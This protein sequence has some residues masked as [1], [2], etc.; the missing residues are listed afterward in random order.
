MGAGLSRKWR[1]EFEHPSSHPVSELGAARQH[2]H[3]H[4]NFSSSGS[5]P[6]QLWLNYFPSTATI[7]LEAEHA[8][9][10]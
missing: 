7:R 1:S 3:F 9:V 10:V 8:A 4:G 5:M 6:Q 2:T